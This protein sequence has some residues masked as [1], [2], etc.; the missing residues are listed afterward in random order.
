MNDE[1]D[2]FLVTKH[3]YIF[4]NVDSDIFRHN[5]PALWHVLGTPSHTWVRAFTAFSRTSSTT[6]VPTRFIT[7]QMR[8]GPS[9]ANKMDGQCILEERWPCQKAPAYPRRSA[10][11]SGPT[12]RTQITVGLRCAACRTALSSSAFPFLFIPIR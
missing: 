8:I 9:P 2:R 3:I 10:H 4:F 12:W 1:V 11:R 6:S 5:E 7:L